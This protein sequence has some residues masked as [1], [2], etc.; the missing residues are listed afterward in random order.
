MPDVVKGSAPTG[1]T[2]SRRG[3]RS[4]VREEQVRTTRRRAIEAAERLFVERGYAGT[5]VTAVANR[6][7]ISAETIYASLQG[8]RGLLEGVIDAAIRGPDGVAIEQQAW[9]AEVGT[10]PTAHDRLA[11]WVAA[12]CRTLARTSPIHA[13]IRGAADREQFAV[14][15]QDT[16]RR[17][18]VRQVTAIAA[19]FLADALRPSLTVPEAGRRYAALLSPELYHLSVEQMGWSPADLQEWLTGILQVDLLIAGP[20]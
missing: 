6:A 14:A 1:S 19:E 20:S 4:P 7:G 3:Y 8:K 12:S 11:G 16:L 5:T 18:R 10:L 9:L 15:L 13:V 17:E 2:G